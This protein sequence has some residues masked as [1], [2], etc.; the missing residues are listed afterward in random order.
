[1]KLRKLVEKLDDRMASNVLTG[2]PT[3]KN[4]YA[5]TRWLLLLV[6]LS[7]V[8][9]HSQQ[10]SVSGT[11]IIGQYYMNSLR[12]AF[13]NTFMVQASNGVWKITVDV[14][15]V[16]N[17]DLCRNERYWDKTQMIT[18]SIFHR[19]ENEITT[20]VAIATISTNPIPES[21]VSTCSFIW[22]AYCSG[23][24]FSHMRNSN[25]L[26]PVWALD[27]MRLHNEGFTVLARSAINE[28][29]PG[30]PKCV[31]YFNDGWV[32]TVGPDRERSVF[33]YNP[34]YDLGFSNFIY[35]SDKWVSRQGVELPGEF[36]AV[37][38]A[39]KYNGRDT[40][41]LSVITDVRGWST[42]IVVSDDILVTP[43]QYEGVIDV[44]DYRHPN[45]RRV[46]QYQITNGLWLARDDPGLKKMVEKRTRPSAERAVVSS[47]GRMLAVA[48]LI[49]VLVIPLFWMAGNYWKRKT[50]NKEHTKT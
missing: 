17:R 37:R 6:I 3:L 31:T 28:K 38:Y 33:R 14:K 25:R 8:A 32:R 16:G 7:G 19:E 18:L 30:L 50:A 26:H 35:Y 45:T 36:H 10:Y 49:I 21:D 9:V 5:L 12:R 2:K 43:P 44:I 34:P 42:Q 39:P 48:M 4:K 40:N 15:P 13:T 47:R 22:L 1:M 27:D 41:D 20:N 46:V 23:N 24:Y 29:P 11:T